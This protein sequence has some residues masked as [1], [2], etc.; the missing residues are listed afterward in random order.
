MRSYTN[1][2]VLGESQM[3]VAYVTYVIYV[4]SGVNAV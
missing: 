1:N 2:S 3:L 4:I